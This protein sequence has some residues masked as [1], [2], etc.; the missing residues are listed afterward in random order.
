MIEQIGGEVGRALARFGPA[1]GMADVVAAWP[2]TVGEEIA[3]HAWPARLGQD[4][5]LHV[6][7]DSSVWAFELAQLAET[8]L[9]RLRNALA[10]SA[11]SALRFAPGRLPELPAPEADRTHPTAIAPG[12]RE[13]ELARELSAVIADEELRSLVARAAAASLARAGADR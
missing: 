10:D 5:T 12:P 7:T 3:R 11:P 8:L 1:T 6:A 13:L 2:A 9:E 4:G